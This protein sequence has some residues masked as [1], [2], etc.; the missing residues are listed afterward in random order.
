MNSNNIHLS[1]LRPNFIDICLNCH[2][3]GIHIKKISVVLQCAN[4][5][6]GPSKGVHGPHI[7]QMLMP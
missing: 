2:H 4:H 3:V 1:A 5:C 6:L 7:L